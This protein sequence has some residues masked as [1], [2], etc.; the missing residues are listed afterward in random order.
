MSDA[1]EALS[2]DYS[3]KLLAH[4]LPVAG[5]IPLRTP[6]AALLHLLSRR[7]RV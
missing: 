6:L 3:D 5:S 7:L 4:P 1:V 2:G